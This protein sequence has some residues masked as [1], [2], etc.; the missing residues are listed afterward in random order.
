VARCRIGMAC[1]VLA[2]AAGVD[3]MA[4]GRAVDLAAGRGLI[5]RSSEP[6]I[7]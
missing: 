5:W 6:C 2:E 1:A 7:E 4:G 3:G